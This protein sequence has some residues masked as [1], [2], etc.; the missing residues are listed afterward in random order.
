MNGST[1]KLYR[2]YSKKINL[3][4]EQYRRLKKDHN[5]AGQAEKEFLKKAMRAALSA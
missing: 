1:A 5:A 2:K 3:Q 4:K